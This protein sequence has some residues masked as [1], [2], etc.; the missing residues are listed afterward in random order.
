V[1]EQVSNVCQTTIVENA[2]EQGQD[3]TIHGW[4]YGL[5]TG[6]LHD[7]NICISCQD[8]VKTHYS[9]AIASPASN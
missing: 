3:L 4:V 9:K 8:D 5:E 6:L 7:L 2:W 1:I